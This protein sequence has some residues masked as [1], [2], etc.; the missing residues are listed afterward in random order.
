MNLLYGNVKQKKVRKEVESTKETA[1]K[2]ATGLG[3][4]DSACPS[5]KKVVSTFTL[6]YFILLYCLIESCQSS[7]KW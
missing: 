5:V 6:F 2:L 3:Q 1:K 7:K 4:A